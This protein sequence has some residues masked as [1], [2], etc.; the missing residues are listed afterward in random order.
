[1]TKQSQKILSG[2][3][4]RKSG[5]QKRAFRAWL[6]R[7]LEGAGWTVTEER[8]R[9]S[10]INVIAG[11]PEKAEVL[12]TAH[13]DTQAVLP[14]P[15]FITPRNLG[16]YL[17]YQL[18]FVVLMFAAVLVV[19]FAVMLL[20]D[21]PRQAAPWPAIAMCIFLMW[22]MFFG[23]ANRH[24]AND[25]TSGVITLLE[26]ALTLPQ[27]L[28]EKACFVFFDNE[29]RGMLGSAAF[30]SK[31]RQVKEE[32]LV[33]NFDCVS[34]GSSVQFFPTKSL[35]KDEAALERIERAFLPQSG[36]TVEVVRGFGFYP[37]DNAS[38]RRAAGVC[39]LKRGKRLGWYMDRIH[40]GRDTVFQE[41]N[42]SLLTD[43]IRRMLE[44]DSP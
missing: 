27:E 39:A 42:I 22:W 31:R 4:V 11:D 6:R 44:E 33:L 20:L 21:L 24:T 12:F 38:F 26:A 32:K 30:A 14:I 3:Q 41:E 9:F 40:T 13:Y 23:K 29:E 19:E 43:G 15:N 8:G 7:E 17:A 35:K 2:F 5:R 1:M 16:W 37:S 25:N 18:V 10:G 36:K 34:D 28:R